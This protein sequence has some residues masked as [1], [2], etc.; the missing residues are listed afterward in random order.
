MQKKLLVSRHVAALIPEV[1]RLRKASAALRDV[2][3]CEPVHTNETGR[4]KLLRRKKRLGEMSET[5]E[6]IRKGTRSLGFDPAV[7]LVSFGEQRISLNDL[8]MAVKA[9]SKATQAELRTMSSDAP[10]GEKSGK[11]TKPEEKRG[12]GVE[13]LIVG[14]GAVIAAVGAWI[15]TAIASLLNG[16][17]DDNARDWIQKSTC[18][19]IKAAHDDDLVNRL[20]ALLDGPTGDDDE[21]AILRLLGCLPPDRRKTISNRVG[22]DELIDNVDGEESA[23]LLTLLVECGAIRFDEMDDDA[24]REYVWTHDPA[25]LNALPIEQVRQLVLNMF[26]GSCGD[27]DEQAILRLLRAQSGA[28]VHQLI[29]MAGMSVED[30]DDN[31]DGDEWDELESLF[32]SHGIS[33]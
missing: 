26:S 5:L 13:L 23:R 10:S 12:A 4:A 14:A 32:A 7:G 29:A 33:T 11:D 19:Q 27:D 1:V 15:G 8:A 28:R 17:D 25:H 30:F 22:V 9:E 3:G 31:V 16:T 20:Q 24:S 6:R 21:A 2:C 18:E